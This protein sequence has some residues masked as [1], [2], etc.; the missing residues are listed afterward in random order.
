MNIIKNLQIKSCNPGA[1]SANQFISQT[2]DHGK[3]ISIN[4]STAQPIA[5]IYQANIDDY[6]TLIQHA[7]QA[8]LHWRQLPAPQRGEIVRQISLALRQKKSELGSLISLEMGKSKQ[9]GDGEVQE[10]IDMA[11]FAVGQS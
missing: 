11:D 2:T 1:Y 7:Q 8:W 5:S 3:I 10:M 6:E 4:P 9:E